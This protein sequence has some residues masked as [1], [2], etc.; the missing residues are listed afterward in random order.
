[1]TNSVRLMV[2]SHQQVGH[3]EQGGVHDAGAGGEDDDG[4]AVTQRRHEHHAD[5]VHQLAADIHGPRPEAERRHYDGEGT[6]RTSVETDV[7]G[8][9]LE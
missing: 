2:V 7:H 5:G 3:G 8:C 4:D 6:G 9:A 1:M